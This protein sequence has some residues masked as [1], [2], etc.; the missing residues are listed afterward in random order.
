MQTKPFNISHH[1]LNMLVQ[2]LVEMQNCYQN[3]IKMFV[4]SHFSIVHKWLNSYLTVSQ[5]YHFSFHR[6]KRCY[7]IRPD[8]RCGCWDCH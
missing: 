3:T 8:H 5:C 4:L 6:S 7:E 1:T 2:Y